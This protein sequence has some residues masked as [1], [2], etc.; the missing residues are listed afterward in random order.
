MTI[1]CLPYP[2]FYRTVVMRNS[3]KIK[4]VKMRKFID[5]PLVEGYSRSS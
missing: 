1:G 5:L 2:Y 3:L 4:F